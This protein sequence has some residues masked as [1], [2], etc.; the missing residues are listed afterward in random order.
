M[1][2]DLGVVYANTCTIGAYTVPAARSRVTL[3]I[4]TPHATGSEHLGSP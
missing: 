4:N 1:V 2:R 3:Q